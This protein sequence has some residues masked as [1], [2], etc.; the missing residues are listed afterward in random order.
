MRLLKPRCP[1]TGRSAKG[2]MMEMNKRI[3]P[4][5]IVLLL[6][7]SPGMAAAE[8]GEVE[9]H[10]LIGAQQINLDKHLASK[11]GQY[12]GEF[13]DSTKP[14]VDIELEY[15]SPDLFLEL[16]GEELAL[17]D[18][19]V[20]IEMGRYGGYEV[21]LK[22]DEQ[23]N[24][25]ST[26]AATVYEGVGSDNLTLPAGFHGGGNVSGDMED[27]LHHYEREIEV[28]TDRKTAFAGFE[29]P[30]GP[31]MVEISYKNT[32]KTG[33]LP[34]TAAFGVSGGNHRAVVLPAPVDYTTN[35]FSASLNF[36]GESSHARVEYF[37][38][39]FD[40][41]NKSF[42][43]ESMWPST[44]SGQNYASE[45][46]ASLA[47]NNSYQRIGLSGGLRDLPLKSAVNA[48]IDFGTMKQDD[49]LL[50]YSNNPN[51]VINTPMPRESAD[52]KIDVTHMKLDVTSKPIDNLNVKLG[53][54]KHETKDKKPNDVF[55]YVTLD[56]GS[57]EEGLD[58]AHALYAAPYSVTRT[59]ITLD[60][61]YMVMPGTSVSLG[62]A[63]KTDERTNRETDKTTENVLSAGVNSMFSMGALGLKYSQGDRKASDYSQDNMFRAYHSAEH[64]EEELHTAPEIMFDNHPDLR[65]FTLADRKRTK[66][67][68]NVTLMPTETASVGLY[69]N[70][71]KDDYND[72]IMGLKSADNQNF[73]IDATVAPAEY[74]TLFVYYTTDTLKTEQSGRSYRGF[75]KAVESADPKRDWAVNIEDKTPTFGFGV[76]VAAMDEK[77]DLSLHYAMSDAT[78]SISFTPGESLTA[79]PLPD[80]K[81]KLTQVD[82]TAKY[83]FTEA[84]SGG[85]GYE[86]EQFSSDDW[87]YDDVPPSSAVIDHVVTLLGAYEDYTAHLFKVFVVYHFGG[88]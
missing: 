72:T 56:T 59:D 26:T 4:L 46:K 38:S 40:N 49:T 32:R 25:I 71:M 13:E 30:A 87:S 2:R 7:I 74:V 48:L 62:Y 76:N 67:G 17:P 8:E 35:D 64:V 29:V 39:N 80:I 44:V 68:A 82:A 16:K 57:Q 81:S 70:S 10:V 28:R 9:G 66:W 55:V 41:S 53:Y 73:T 45:G 20:E 22:Y 88:H 75:A 86:Y 63:N 5:V 21:E 77:L 6:A 79:E 37:L 31:L 61:S 42:T 14:L 51:S 27:S 69:F 58:G 84:F 33:E 23:P 85:L 1:V 24:V 3:Y 60:A 50:P 15:E 47:P 18:R 65:K 19:S 54:N 36:K 43:W 11:Y 12:T 34:Y 52:V 83:A 78:S